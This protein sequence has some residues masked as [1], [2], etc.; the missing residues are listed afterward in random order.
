[1]LLGA[2][3]CFGVS[4]ACLAYLWWLALHAPIAE[5]DERG[6]R[7]LTPE[8]IREIMEIDRELDDWLN[9]WRRG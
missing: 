4:V 6:F 5:Q 1:V 7:T 8:E 9:D 3:I 2:T